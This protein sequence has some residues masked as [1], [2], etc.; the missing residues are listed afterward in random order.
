M[1][2]LAR[3][4]LVFVLCVVFAPM[5]LAQ[6]P[7][8]PPPEVINWLTAGIGVLVAAVVPV[9]TAVVKTYLAKLPSWASPVIVFL[10]TTA[11]TT[12][13]GIAVPAGKFSWAAVLGLSFL[14]IVI[15]ELKIA[16]FGK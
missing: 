12:I 10:M 13:A 15:R 5:A 4:F 1:K 11:A 16:L 3:A 2:F 8:G 9:L 6:V 7:A 14:S